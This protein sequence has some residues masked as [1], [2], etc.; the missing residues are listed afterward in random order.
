MGLVLALAVP[1]IALGQAQS[2]TT[3]SGDGSQSGD[4]SNNQSNAQSAVGNGNQQN[5]TN[6]NCVAGRDCV[7]NNITNQNSGSTRTFER[8]PVRVRGRIVRR[9]TLAHTGSDLRLLFLVGGLM[10][11]GGIGVLTLRRRG[12]NS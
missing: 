3:G 12:F 5:A 4:V 11:A 9:V 1:A 2:G 10:T 7:N 8:A 6:Q